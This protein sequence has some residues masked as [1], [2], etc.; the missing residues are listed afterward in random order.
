MGGAPI[1]PPKVIVEM[2]GTAWVPAPT[3]VPIPTFLSQGRTHMSRG[4]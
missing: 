3:A 1:S 2:D 4:I